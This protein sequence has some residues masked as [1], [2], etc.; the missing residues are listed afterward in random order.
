MVNVF[1]LALAD[2][3][4]LNEALARVQGVYRQQLINR[5]QQRLADGG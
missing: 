5:L 4:P 2:V 3:E 1:G